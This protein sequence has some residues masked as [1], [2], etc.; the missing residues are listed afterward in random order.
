MGDANAAAQ[1]IPALVATSAGWFYNNFI[2]TKGDALNGVSQLNYNGHVREVAVSRGSVPSGVLAE[3]IDMNAVDL[4]GNVGGQTPVNLRAPSLDAAT[5]LDELGRANADVYE[6]VVPELESVL[7]TTSFEGSFTKESIPELKARLQNVEMAAT[8][9]EEEIAKARKALEIISRASDEHMQAVYEQFQAVETDSAGFRDT[10]GVH[11]TEIAAQERRI[12]AIKAEFINFSND[13]NES[14]GNVATAAA[15]ETEQAFVRAASELRAQKQSI[16]HAQSA[17]DRAQSA[18]DRAQ[19]TAEE[20]NRSRREDTESQQ[21]INTIYNTRFGAAEEKI[22][23]LRGDVTAAADGVKSANTRMETGFKNLGTRITAQ[24]E[25]IEKNKQLSELQKQE[26]LDAL[27]AIEAKL[28]NEIAANKEIATGAVNAA[29]DLEAAQLKQQKALETERARVSENEKYFQLMAGIQGM[30]MAATLYSNWSRLCDPD[31]N[32]VD[33]VTAVLPSAVGLAGVA[34]PPMTAAVGLAISPFTAGV[35]ATVAV[36][37]RMFVCRYLGTTRPPATGTNRPVERARLQNEI[38]K[39]LGQVD[40]SSA[41]DATKRLRETLGY[42]KTLL[43]DDMTVPE[44]MVAV[45]LCKHLMYDQ[46]TPTAPNRTDLEFVAGSYFAAA[47]QAVRSRLSTF[48]YGETTY[49]QRF[50]DVFY[51]LCGLQ[52]SL[53]LFVHESPL[54]YPP[55]SFLMI[56]FGSGAGTTTGRPSFAGRC[57]QF[58]VNGIGVLTSSIGG[59]CAVRGGYNETINTTDTSIQKVLKNSLN[60]LSH[61]VETTV[62]TGKRVFGA[63]PAFDRMAAANRRAAP[64]R[65]APAPAPAAATG[66]VP[67]PGNRAPASFPRRGD[68]YMQRSNLSAKVRL[69]DEALSLL[70]VLIPGQK[71]TYE[72]VLRN[73][74]RYAPIMRGFRRVRGVGSSLNC[75]IEVSDRLVDSNRVPLVLFYDGKSDSPYALGMQDM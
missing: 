8:A 23:G 55:E 7:N 35:G 38:D 20:A 1:A 29:T 54:K 65:P 26:Q 74:S 50:S 41:N 32:V 56:A 11:G 64:P 67:T 66:G 39:I 22:K 21:K 25:L 59:S 31:T 30:Q 69:S 36:A 68:L 18:A 9:N 5:I 62:S 72:T 15:A 71:I 48:F 40:S 17:A 13:V 10:L 37:I 61:I 16:D 49:N 34:V 4:L 75:V 19:S 73:K 44:A 45:S 63:G 28:A 6:P 60:V 24:R 58:P 43:E 3:P 2:G 47:V 46:A 70:G 52:S 53:C 27:A 14:L 33:A 57:I 42:A 51:A 12:G